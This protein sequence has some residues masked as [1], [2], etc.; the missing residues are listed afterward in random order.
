MVE[1]LDQAPLPGWREFERGDQRGEQTDIADA[2]V[3]RRKAVMGGRFEAKCEHFRVCRRDVRSPEG[4]DPGLNEFGRLL[5]AVAEDRAEITKS[6]HLSGPGRGEIVARDRDGEIGP[7]AQFAALRIGGEKHALADV[8][9]GE[10]EKW[11]RRLQDCWRHPRIARTLIG[12][13]ERLRP[14][15]GVSPSLRGRRGVHDAE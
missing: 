10:I 8:L 14:R 13:D 11:L 6:F 2:D 7:Q 9:A 3:G 12:P 5:R 4:F 15:V 1:V